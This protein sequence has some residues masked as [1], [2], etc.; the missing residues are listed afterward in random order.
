MVQ[1]SVLIPAHDEAGVIAATLEPFAGRATPPVLVMCNGC[2]DDTAGIARRMLPQARVIERVQAGKAAAINAGL[3]LLPPG[4][5][6]VMDADIRVTVAALDALADVLEEPG[7]NVVAPAAMLDLAGADRWVRGYYAVF[8]RHRYLTEG[9][10]GSG[11]YG[12]SRTARDLLG[13]MPD[14]MSDDD[15]IRHFFDPATQRRVSR[16]RFGQ[17]VEAGLSP[18]RRLAE[19]LRSEARWRAGDAAVRHG[20]THGSR[21]FAGRL[22][23]SRTDLHHLRH[24]HELP[25]TALMRY[26]AIKLAGRAFFHVNRLRG[27]AHIWHRDASSR[28]AGGQ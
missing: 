27:R 6:I 26:A 25:W 7:V 21:T 11:V 28:Q 16:D 15:Y 17:A 3:A 13:E 5:V 19:L 2:S 23:T 9:V 8:A 22:R 14:V 12:L 10:G 4:P 20:T 24:A 18:P 1:Y